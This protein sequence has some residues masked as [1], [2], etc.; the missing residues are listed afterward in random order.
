MHC[1]VTRKAARIPSTTRDKSLAQG[2]IGSCFLYQDYF[3][4]NGLSSHLVEVRKGT[5]AM[6]SLKYSFIKLKFKVS[7]QTH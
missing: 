4:N 7:I 5:R 3:I 6:L 1:A 2:W